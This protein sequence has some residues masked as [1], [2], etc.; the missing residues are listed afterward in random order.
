MTTNLRINMT[1]EFATSNRIIFGNGALKK[2]APLAKEMGSKAL[3]VAG[4]SIQ[5][6]I[7]LLEQLQTHR[8]AY[9]IF[10]IVGEPTTDSIDAALKKARESDVD[11]VVSIGGG[12]VIDTG[13]AVAA[14]LTNPGKA[15]DY[16][17]VIGKGRPLINAPLPHIAI[18]T[19]AGTGT[20][21][22]KN[23][24]LRSTTHNVKVSL[25]H[26]R[27]IPDVAIIDPELTYSLPPQITAGVGTD[28]LTQLIEPFVCKQSNPLTD[29]L[30]REGIMRAARSLK[31]AYLNGA[32]KQAR[33]DMAVASLFGGL[34]L[35]NAKLGAV[36]GFA[37][38]LGGMFNAPHGALC[39]R[40]LPLVI[41]SNIKA[42]RLRGGDSPALSRYEEVARLLTGAGSAKAEDAVEWTQRLCASL[43]IPGLS[44]F[45][46]TSEHIATSVTKA[47]KASSM[48]GNPIE[49]TEK[50]LENILQKAL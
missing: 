12:S 48:K 35:A 25:R 38:P 7:P 33:E 4:R 46:M 31:S 11:F 39:A 23:A 50:E 20:E 14:L 44:T 43:H 28:A 1:F 13:K 30:C 24:V 47:Q 36:H 45:G 27:M 21:A 8:V 9:S 40:L 42:L 49:L 16:L 22:T 6:V 18:P 15:L 19:T 5:R 41:E 26:N 37:G 10:H 17:E 2:A 3:V 29:A 32:D 34:A